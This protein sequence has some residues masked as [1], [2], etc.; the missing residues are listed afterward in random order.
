MIWYMGDVGE[1]LII[2]FADEV[3]VC[4]QGFVQLHFDLTG[5]KFNSQ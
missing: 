3:P 2:F 5:F 4:L 1:S